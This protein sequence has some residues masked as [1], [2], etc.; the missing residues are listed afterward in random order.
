M[1][2]RSGLSLITFRKAKTIYAASDIKNYTRKL[3]DSAIGEARRKDI[4]IVD[5]FPLN[6]LFALRESCATSGSMT[7]NRRNTKSASQ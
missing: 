6:F 1:I 7:Q 4:V 5:T 3:S 2:L